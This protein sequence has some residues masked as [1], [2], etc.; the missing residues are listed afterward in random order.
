MLRFIAEI[1]LNHNG[2]FGVLEEMIKQSSFNGAD[3]VKFQLGWRDGEGEINRIDS[4]QIDRIMSLCQIYKIAPLF[5]II[6]DEAFDLL[7]DYEFDTVKIA[8]RTVV[9]NP[10]LCDK[11][12][13]KYSNVFISLGFCD[14]GEIPFDGDNIEYLNCT[15]KYPTDPWETKTSDFVFNSKICGYSDHSVGIESCLCA[16]AYGATVIEK[17][18]TLDKSNTTIRDHACGA[19]FDEFGNM[20]RL[21][22]KI[23]FVAN[24]VQS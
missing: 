13:R 10:G 22:K 20:V 12:I 11:I 24:L 2:N 21:S 16:V 6:S 1:G 14:E 9:D 17:H 8:S 19:T 5:S 7:N 4:N 23:A 3:F 18:V 15:S